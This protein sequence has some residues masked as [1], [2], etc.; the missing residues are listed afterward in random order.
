M[1]VIVIH[2]RNGLL[3]NNKVQLIALDI[4]GTLLNSDGHISLYTEQVI[5]E[6]LQKDIHVVL[7]TGRPLQLCAD[8]ANKLNITD[9]II[10]NNGAEIWKDQQNVISRHLMDPKIVK[11]L[12]M[13]GSDNDLL[14]WMVTPEKLFRHSTR[15]ASFYDF[16]WLKFGFGHLD[17]E[18]IKVLNYKLAN[19]DDLEVT[20]SSIN[21]IELNKKGVNKGKAIKTVCD[22]LNISLNNVMAIGDNLN[23]L[24]MIKDVGLGVAVS[25][26]TEEL[27]Q[28]AKFVTSSNDEDGVAKAI[29]R[30]A[31]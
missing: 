10:T 22:N 6:A 31:L 27:K 3:V 12:W 7:S 19:Y 11:Q 8:I 2:R 21:N 29:K 9:Y 26:A 25:N 20:S 13:F 5:K 4:D 23:D 17:E 16:D 14:T 15:P 30:F 18:I 28:T 1:I 24:Q